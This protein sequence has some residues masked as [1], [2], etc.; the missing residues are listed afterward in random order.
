MSGIVK[1]E[2]RGIEKSFP[3]VKALSNVNFT[4]KQGSVHGL[5]G[6]NG[7]G[8]STL[9]KILNG[10]Y[11]PDAGQILIDGEEVRI[12]SPLDA[13]RLGIAMIFQELNYIPEITIEEFLFLGREPVNRF[14]GVDW[15]KIRQDT[16]AA[17]GGGASLRSHHSA[18]RLKRI[19]YSGPGNP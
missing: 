3:G 14:G 18:E 2:M 13:R 6:E 9:M 1:L 15:K 5:C 12:T 10:V 8:K 16:I 7:A 17:A 19:R 4:V 11:Q